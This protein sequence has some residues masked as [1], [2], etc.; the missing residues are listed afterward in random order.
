MTA[1]SRPSWLACAI[2][3][4]AF[5]ILVYQIDAKSLWVDELTSV[6][7]ASRPGVSAV[8]GGVIEGERRPPL[9]HLMLHYWIS[10][11][12]DSDLSLRML[13]VLLGTTAVALTF[14]MG[15]TLLSRQA[16]LTA[17]SLLALSP[18]FVLYARMI[19]YYSLCVALGLLS[20]YFFLRLTRGERHDERWPRLGLWA[21]Y[22]GATGLLVYADYPAWALV[23]G[24][25]LFLML[26]WRRYRSMW[27][28]WFAAQAVLAATLLPWLSLVSLQA[29]R[30]LITADFSVGP[31][32]VAMKLAYPLYSFSVGETIFPW[33]PA[34]LVGLVIAAIL[35]LR[36][37]TARRDDGEAMLFLGL[38]LIL[39]IAFTAA[40]TSTVAKDITFLATASRS[41]FVLPFFCLIL[42][43]GLASF[44]RPTVWVVLLWGLVLVWGLS[45][46]NY[47][48]GRDFHN[49]IFVIP[50]REMA[51]EVAQRAEP[52]DVVVSDGDSAFAYYYLKEYDSV[53][54]HFY[55]SPTTDAIG[56]IQEQQS[57]RVW[58]ITLG[59][60][61][62]REVAPTELVAWL[63]RGYVR[64]AHRGYVEQDA[65]YQ[66][67]KERLLHRPAYEYKAE[68]SL[69]QREGDS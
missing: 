66:E 33:N 37:L 50:A 30:D 9:Y 25:N 20:C 17:S 39:P 38:F 53:A 60:D 68:L 28:R 36:G 22:L 52:D 45:L 35:F 40:I 11:A 3:L 5:A 62:T 43:Q 57:P 34:A 67:V 18:T 54:R 19:R 65:I 69:Y 63:E 56:Y 4:V 42:A 12:G 59:R 13:S 41:L 23:V 10:A 26:R 48:R 8:L 55:S 44:R 24:Q 15:A 47:Y 27:R 64:I 29:A 6:E 49:P 61:R 21:A 16:G 31:M 7:V 46:G 14:R 2:C 32:A 1:S 58:L 51:V